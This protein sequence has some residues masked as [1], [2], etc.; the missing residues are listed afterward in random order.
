MWCGPVPLRTPPFVWFAREE[1]ID[2]KVKVFC[3]LSLSSCCSVRSAP[4]ARWRCAVGLV[5][6]LLVGNMGRFFRLIGGCRVVT[7]NPYFHRTR[8]L[9]VVLLIE[10]PAVTKTVFQGFLTPEQLTSIMQ[11][12]ELGLTGPELHLVIAE[13]DD[14]ADGTIDV[15]KTT[16]AFASLI[17][18]FFSLLGS[19]RCWVRAAVGFYRCWVLLTISL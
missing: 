6:L 11:N 9:Q 17:N 18:S 3:S 2:S 8:G 4:C 1:G 19:S 5:S 13:A 16:P 7:S 14:N 15:R 12:A 10:A